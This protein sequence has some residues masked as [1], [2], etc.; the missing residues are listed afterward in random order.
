MAQDCVQPAENLEKIMSGKMAGPSIAAL[1]EDVGKARLTGREENTA[2]FISS[3]AQAL[4][5]VEIARDVEKA[6]AS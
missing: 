1:T 4:E 5:A 2:R 3:M 6:N